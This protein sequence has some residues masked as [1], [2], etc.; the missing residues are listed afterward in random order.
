[1]Q[2]FIKPFNFSFFSITGWGIDLTNLDHIL[3]SR[4]ITLPTKVHLVVKAMFSPV[5]MYGYEIWTVGK[6][7][8]KELILLNCDVEQDS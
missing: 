6:L 8:T 1:M 5:V 2:V 4:D 7:S 3:K